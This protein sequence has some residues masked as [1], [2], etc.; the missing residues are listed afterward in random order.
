[1]FTS[2]CLCGFVSVEYLRQSWVGIPK[3]RT[4]IRYL[5]KIP[6]P[7]SVFGI[8]KNTDTDN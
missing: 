5:S 4:D 2:T 7:M 3:Y 6:I 8:T 1:M